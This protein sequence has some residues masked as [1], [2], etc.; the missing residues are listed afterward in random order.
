MRSLP[1]A[2]VASLAL[3]A[4]G[5]TIVGGGT[6]AAVVASVNHLAGPTRAHVPVGAGTLIGGLIGLAIDLAVIS[7]V[8]DVIV[9][10]CICD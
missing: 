7:A 9:H 8:S 1:L 6:G 4:P 10:S 5:C 3:A 2:I